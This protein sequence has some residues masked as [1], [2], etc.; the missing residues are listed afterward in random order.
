MKNIGIKRQ[1]EDENNENNEN[2]ENT[3]RRKMEI[4]N[5]YNKKNYFEKIKD[6]IKR[7]HDI[8]YL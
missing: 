3:K 1:R 2:N 7:L 5:I 8:M 6:I 4:T